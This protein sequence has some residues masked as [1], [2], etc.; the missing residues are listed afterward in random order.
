M[1]KPDLTQYIILRKDLL[2]LNWNLGSIIA[3]ACHA[4]SAAL[5]VFIN[6]KNVID[7]TE[8]IQHMTKVILQ[9]ENESLLK[10]L[11]NDL[12]KHNIDH[13]LWIE[14]PENIITCLATK[15][16]SKDILRPYFNTLK[17]YK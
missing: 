10:N 12:H 3:Q 8:N 17:L 9:I 5:I 4:S 13:K 1:V 15:P 6:D 7:Y 14:Q 2:Q 16:Y 11:S